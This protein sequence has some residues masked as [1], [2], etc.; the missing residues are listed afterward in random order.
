MTSIAVIH[1][2]SNQS[3][4]KIFFLIFKPCIDRG[5]L[6]QYTVGLSSDTEQKLHADKQYN[7]V[8][9]AWELIPEISIWPAGVVIFYDWEFT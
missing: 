8:Y 9:L 6:L 4:M 5:L 7:T 2:G 1:G 3:D